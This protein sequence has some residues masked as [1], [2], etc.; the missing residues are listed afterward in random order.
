MLKGFTTR[1]NIEGEQTIHTNLFQNCETI[2]DSHGESIVS[3]IHLLRYSS[4]GFVHGIFGLN[5][6]F[7]NKVEKEEQRRRGELA[8]IGPRDAPAGKRPPTTCTEQALMKTDE[9]QN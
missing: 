3:E 4:S 9:G 7:K 5:S 1:V 2:C 8:M 6:K